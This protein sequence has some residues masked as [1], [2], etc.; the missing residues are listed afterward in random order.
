MRMVKNPERENL[1]AYYYIYSRTAYPHASVDRIVHWAL[2]GELEA[3]AKDGN[4]KHCFQSLIEKTNLDVQHAYSI[5]RSMLVFGDAYVRLVRDD[6]E[7]IVRLHHLSPKDVEIKCDEEDNVTEFVVKFGDE[8]VSY[9]PKNVLHFRWK[10]QENTPYGTSI[11]KGLEPIVKRENRIMNDFL[12]A[13]EAQAQGRAVAFDSE[14]SLKE[15][16]AVPFIIAKHTQVPIGLL[17]MRVRNE[18]IHRLQ[19]KDF[20]ILCQSLRDLIRNEIVEKII[21]PEIERKGFQEIARIDWKRKSRPSP[22]EAE[23]I[24]ENMQRGI[25]P[26]EEALKQLG[27]KEYYV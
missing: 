3:I 4:V 21:K 9:S 26:L 22:K 15:L 6:D 2:D 17:T 10:P 24:V 1:D 19:M 27:L 16:K 5:L 8:T 18:T 25:I 23:R 13:F 7:N 14:R 20:E 11:L 12:R